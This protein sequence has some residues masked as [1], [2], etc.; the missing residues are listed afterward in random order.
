MASTLVIY[1][2]TRITTHLP[3][4]KGWKA[5]PG[6]VTHSGHFTHKAVTCEIDNRRSRKVRQPKT[7]ILTTEPRRQPDGFINDA[8]CE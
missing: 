1:I 4:P 3:T 6:W 2:I 7:D 8:L 5:E